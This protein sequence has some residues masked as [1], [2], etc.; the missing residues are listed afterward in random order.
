MML[1]RTESQLRTA[2]YSY[3][4]SNHILRVSSASYS[5]QISNRLLPVTKLFYT[6][7]LSHSSYLIISR[8]LPKSSK[9]M[10]S[11]ASSYQIIS[12]RLPKSSI[13][14]CSHISSRLDALK[15]RA[16]NIL[17]NVSA[18]TRRSQPPLEEQRLWNPPTPE[19]NMN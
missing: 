15:W 3:R 2:S 7:V 9:Q 8:R 18:K 13:Q 1:Q 12:R 16:K 11:H 6:N 19:T 10:C 4:I 14:M 5:N 17:K